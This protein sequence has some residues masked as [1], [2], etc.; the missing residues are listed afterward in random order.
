M[1]LWQSHIM[2]CNAMIRRDSRIECWLA[3]GT[4]C[5]CGLRCA[6]AF[7]MMGVLIYIAAKVNLML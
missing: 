1:R 3:D 2:S 6:I 4:Y 5:I 7:G